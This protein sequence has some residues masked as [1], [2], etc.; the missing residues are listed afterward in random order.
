MSPTPNQFFWHNGPQFVYKIR[1]KS[2]GGGGAFLSYFVHKSGVGQWSKKKI[3]I[4]ISKTAMQL[5][6]V[7]FHCMQTVLVMSMRFVLGDD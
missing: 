6:V 1:Q 5:G 3:R 2:P 7:N 4:L